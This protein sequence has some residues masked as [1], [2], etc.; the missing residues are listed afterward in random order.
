MKKILAP[1]LLGLALNACAKQIP[2]AAYSGGEIATTTS[3]VSDKLEN[4]MRVDA[5]EVQAICGPELTDITSRKVVTR[6]TRNPNANSTENSTQNGTVR[7]IKRT[8]FG[9]P[10]CVVKTSTE[11]QE[12]GNSVRTICR[13]VLQ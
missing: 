1:A 11:H 2:P 7:I 6:M 9:E 13:Y 10:S 5:P 12:E 4:C 3:S 8:D